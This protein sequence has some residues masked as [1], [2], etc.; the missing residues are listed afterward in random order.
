MKRRIHKDGSNSIHI[1]SSKAISTV[2]VSGETD[3][4]GVTDLSKF[5]TVWEENFKH[6]QVT[7]HILKFTA[8]SKPRL[9]PTDP[10]S[11][12]ETMFSARLPHKSDKMKHDSTH[13]ISLVINLNG[14]KQ[15][16]C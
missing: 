5:T 6:G 11:S 16:L 9:Q 10:Y 1:Y 12:S 8:S 3:S 4:Y 7:V 15:K 13:Q 2:P 14:R